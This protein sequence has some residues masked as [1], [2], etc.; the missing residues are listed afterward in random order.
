MNNVS[1]DDTTDDDILT[2]ICPPDNSNDAPESKLMC[3]I[4]FC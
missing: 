4:Y 2:M 3:T 1:Y